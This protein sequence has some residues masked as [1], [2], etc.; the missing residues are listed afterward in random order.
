MIIYHKRDIKSFVDILHD[1]NLRA[2]EDTKRSNY[3]I[4]NKLQKYIYFTPKNQ[5]H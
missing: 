5:C 4:H 1:G 2:G 3:D